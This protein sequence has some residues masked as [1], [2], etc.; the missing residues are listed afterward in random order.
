MSRVILIKYGELTTKK[1][2]RNLF[3]NQLNQNINHKLK[4]LDLIIIK[5]RGRAFIEFNNPSDLD[6]IIQ[7]LRQVFGIHAIV[8][9][10]KVTTD[11][12]I[13]KSSSL[14]LMK[15]KEFKTF[16]IETKRSNK[17]FP[18]KSLEVNKALG[19]YLLQ[20]I[21]DINVD[22]HQ[23]DITLMLEIRKDYSY[24]Y[25]DEIKG[26]GGYPV[27]IQGKG[28]LMLS[29]GIDSPVAGFLALKRGIKLECIYFESLPHTSIEARNKV[30]NLI[31][32]L[33]NYDSNIKLH[34]IPF[35]K[36]QEEIYQKTDAAYS[37]TI[38]RRMM[39]RITEKLALKN[40]CLVIING[41]NIGQVASQTLT[42]LFVIN[43]VTTM[44]VIR[45][46]SCLD[47]MEII[48]LANKIG[49]Y[50]ISILP[51]EDCCTIF[52]PKHPVINPRLDKTKELEKRINY[53]ELIKESL[54]NVITIEVS[55]HSKEEFQDLL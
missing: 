24:L 19:S 40:N 49:T 20:N 52:V 29:G 36:I 23:P 6:E 26:L 11:L 9:A 34:I 21:P 31:K 22:V 53:Q 33:T 28:M 45:P 38:M 50:D 14:N 55:N 13:I 46:V 10:D 43:E 37:M 35:T 39:Y 48:S 4:H 47:K 32:K 54:D 7:Q 17:D 12:D 27:S 15:E 1:G 25:M 30:I 5:E 16:K 2:N 42:S 44:P 8:I 51:Y 3:I 18:L 41:E